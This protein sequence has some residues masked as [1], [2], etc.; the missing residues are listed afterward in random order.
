MLLVPVCA[1]VSVH[2]T[3]H[4][5]MRPVCTSGMCVVCMGCVFFS[6]GQTL[7]LVVVS[8][9][10]SAG[11]PPPFLVENL[12]AQELDSPPPLPFCVH[13]HPWVSPDCRSGNRS[14]SEFQTY[15][16]GP[17]QHSSLDIQQ[18]TPAPHSPEQSSGFCSDVLLLPR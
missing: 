18:A 12:R 2:C 10:L 6:L 13:S 17:G 7:G 15:I 9:S 4:V 16:Q 5:Y 3:K 8:L 1:H 11:F 14:A